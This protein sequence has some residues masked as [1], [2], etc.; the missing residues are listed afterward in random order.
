MPP[1]QHGRPEINQDLIARVL[2]GD[3]RSIS[4]LISVVEN[5]PEAGRPYL[6]ELFQHT[7]KSLKIGITGSPGSGKS[8]LVDQLARYYRE[9]DRKVGIIAVD[10]TSPYS[11][12]AILGDRIRMQS[13]S[14]DRGTFIRSMATRGHLGGLA[15]ATGD[16][17][18]VLDAAGFDLIIVETVG[19]GQDEV[20][21]VRAADVTMVIL[22]PGMGDDV[23]AMKAGIMEIGD[24][25]VINK[26][27]RPGADRVEVELKALISMSARADGWKPPIVRTVASEG[28]GLAE[29][30]AAIENY[31]SLVRASQF[32]RNRSIRI[33]R[34]RMLELARAMVL[35]SLLADP[36]THE[37]MDRLARE[38]TDRVVD[39]YSAAEE[40][41]SRLSEQRAPEPAR[42]TH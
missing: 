10:P 36:A 2:E 14:V 22:V 3:F 34:E 42:D 24:V 35:E 11:G 9:E 19:V 20:D 31:L 13:R 16:V 27:D 4:R 15:R 1:A 33:Q 30:A 21:I 5:S 12:G 40:L 32:Q 8:T 37:L 18:T 23:Q 38:I 6:R 29:C 7:G 41:L 39:P 17:L 25:F 28:R 26:A